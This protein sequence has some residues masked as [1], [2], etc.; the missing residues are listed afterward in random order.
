MKHKWMDNMIMQNY[1]FSRFIL[2]IQHMKILFVRLKDSVNYWV[3]DALAE[4]NI[5]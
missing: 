2:R 1:I 5:M 4:P 3:I